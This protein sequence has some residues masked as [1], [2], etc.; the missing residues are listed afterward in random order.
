MKPRRSDDGFTL[1]ELL[2]AITILSVVILA[3]GNAVIGYLSNSN[4]TQQRLELSHDAQLS[5]VYFG[6]DVAS[7]GRRGEPTANGQPFLASIQLNAAYN[8]DGLSCGTTATPVAQLRL[9]ADDWDA[10]VSPPVLRTQIIAYYLK[11]AGDVSELHRM[12][13]AGS[14][15]PLSD[16]VIAH[17]VDPAQGLTVTCS[18]A[19]AATPPPLTVQLSFRVVAPSADPYPIVLTGQRRQT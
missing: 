6:P 7:L 17:N 19:C 16:V 18:S 4:A 10:S 5:A 8:A 2:I 14:A 11:P 1:I 9:L 15:A 12:K 3:L 13:C